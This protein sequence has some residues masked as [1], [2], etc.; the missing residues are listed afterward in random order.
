VKLVKK[1]NDA[2]ANAEYVE[3][4]PY[5]FVSTGGEGLA[6]AIF[7]RYITNAETAKRSGFPPNVR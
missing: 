5:F 1:K 3:P 4:G 7:K 2:E 6:H